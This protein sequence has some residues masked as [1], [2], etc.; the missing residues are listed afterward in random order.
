MFCVIIGII[1]TVGMDAV[2][3]YHVALVGFVSAGLVFTTSSVNAFIYSS[4]PA[5]EAGAAGFI[6]LSMVTVS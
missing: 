6:L 1:I 2:Y 4:D 3:T 5:K